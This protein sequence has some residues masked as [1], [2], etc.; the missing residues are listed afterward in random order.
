LYALLV[1]RPKQ[2]LESL[3]T[4]LRNY[5][6]ESKFAGNSCAALLNADA[7]IPDVVLLSID[8][9][10]EIDGLCEYLKTKKVPVIELLPSEDL[11]RLNPFIDDFVLKPYRAGEIVERVKRLILKKGPVTSSDQIK[12]GNLIIDTAKYEVY[13]NGVLVELTFKEY[14]LLKFL[15]GNPGR[16]F[17][18]DTLL[19]QVWGDDYFGGDRTVDVHIRRLRGKIEDD[20]QAYIDTVRNIGYRFKK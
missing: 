17:T 11:S 14:E 3:V 1:A 5:K 10:P 20:A 9:S 13:R 12:A 16:V 2:E 8:R 19:N 18:R 6:I 15:A 4:E 7:K